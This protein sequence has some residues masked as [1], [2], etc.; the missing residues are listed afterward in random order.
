[1]SKGTW[2]YSIEVVQRLA[3]MVTSKAVDEEPN[4][5]DIVGPSLQ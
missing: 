2:G 1:M 4:P 5:R 3:G